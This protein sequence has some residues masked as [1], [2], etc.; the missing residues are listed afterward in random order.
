M[1]AAN[2][3]AL[4]RAVFESVDL[5][6]AEM[7]H[8]RRLDLDLAHSGCADHDICRR[9]PSAG[10]V[11]SICLPAS[12]GQ[13]V[14]FDGLPFDGPVLL[15]AAFNNC[16]SHFFS[17]HSLRRVPAGCLAPFAGVGEA[18]VYK[19]PPRPIRNCQGRSGRYYTC[20]PILCQRLT[21]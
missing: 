2:A 4:L 21:L 17:S 5:R 6:A 7:V 1:P 3:D 14:H 11:R 18:G 13:A 16:I 19:Q 8:H 20:R 9:L 10:C 15:A 12:T